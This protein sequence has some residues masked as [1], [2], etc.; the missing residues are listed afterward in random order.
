M[1][2]LD[3]LENV[4]KKMD[5]SEKVKKESVKKEVKTKKKPIQEKKKYTIPKP[6]KIIDP[7]VAFRNH[8]V[9]I[10]EGLPDEVAVPDDVIK[11]SDS[12][13]RK[14]SEMTSHASSLL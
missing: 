1:G 5:S 9:T 13:R 7:R 3:Y 11:V 4:E 8:A 14:S 10:L 12:P 2:F 6:K